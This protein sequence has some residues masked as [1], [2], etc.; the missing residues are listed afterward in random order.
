MASG[1]RGLAD[2]RRATG[3]AACHAGIRVHRTTCLPPER[4]SPTARSATP[5]SRALRSTSRPPGPSGA[6]AGCCERPRSGA[7][8]TS[9]TCAP[10]LDRHRGRPG[11]VDAA[12]RAGGPRSRPAQRRASRTTSWSSSA[13]AG[14]PGP[15]C[16]CRWAPTGSTSS[17]GPSAWWSRPTTSPA[18]ASGRASSTTTSGRVVRRP[19]VR[20]GAGDRTS[21]AARLRRGRT[22]PAGRAGIIVAMTIVVAGEALFDLVLREDGTA[23]RPPG[24][25]AVQR[26]ADDRAAGRAGHVPGRDLHRRLRPAAG[27]DARRRRRRSPGG[28]QDRSAHD[29]R[30]RRAL[31]RGRRH[32]PLLH[33]GHRRGDERS[34]PPPCPAQ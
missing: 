4:S 18:M 3:A 33:R 17:G 13:P 9:A 5:A 30:G 34:R 26:R 10:V 19:A 2:H 22:R 11:T 28:A 6:C 25:R 1:V 15:S 7:C 12:R 29:P 8:S 32:V 24:R 23:E 27:R 20:R 21:A 14:S 16:R 31:G